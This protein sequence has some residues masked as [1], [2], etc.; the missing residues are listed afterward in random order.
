V[1]DDSWLKI[2][3]LGSFWVAVINI[4]RTSFVYI[5]RLIS[6]FSSWSFI[7]L[8][9]WS[10]FFHWSFDR[11]FSILIVWSFFFYP[12]RLTVLSSFWSFD[13]SLFIVIVWSFFLIVIVW[14]FFSRLDHFI[15]FHIDRPSIYHLLIV[16]MVRSISS[17]CHLYV[18]LIEFS[19]PRSNHVSRARKHTM[20]RRKKLNQKGKWLLH[21]VVPASLAKSSAG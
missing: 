20:Q 10:F 1:I 2:P 13:R 14:S 12:D 17:V 21:R 11:S 8:I 3:S 6:H 16:N 9:V 19:L 4:L 18:W 7:I 5:Y 15:L